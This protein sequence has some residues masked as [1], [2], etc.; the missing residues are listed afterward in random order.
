MK[1]L[2]REIKETIARLGNS[3]SDADFI[4]DQALSILRRLAAD[5]E[6]SPGPEWLAGSFAEL[7]R[8]WVGSIPWCSELSREI[9]RLII[10]YGD[11]T[12]R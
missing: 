5:A 6:T 9:E 10:M 1:T 4:A 11:L 3:P 7:N 8:F 12:G 2:R